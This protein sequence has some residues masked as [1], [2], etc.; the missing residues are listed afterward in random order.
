MRSISQ[1]GARALGPLH[2]SKPETPGPQ[3][4]VPE[5]ALQPCSTH[6]LRGKSFSAAI[7]AQLWGG[8]EP[9]LTGLWSK[10]PLIPWKPWDLL[11]P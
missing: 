9:V 10:A 1:Y 4:P 5:D 2:S 8:S 3:F 7:S 11:H 6:E